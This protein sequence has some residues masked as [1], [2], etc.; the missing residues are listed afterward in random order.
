MAVD[1][2]NAGHSRKVAVERPNF[3]AVVGGNRCNQ[4]VGETKTLACC[5]R[6]VQPVVNACPRLIPWKEDRKC[7]E[8]A[9]EVRIVTIGSSAQ[10]L[11]ANGSR[12][13]NFA[14]V[15][16]SRKM[17]RRG[18]L[19]RA[20]RFDPN[21]R[22]DEDHDDGRRRDLGRSISRLMCPII[23]LSSSMR[24]RRTTSCSES[25]TASVSDSAPSR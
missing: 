5:P 8:D 11:N 22:V 13:D 15:E 4:K 24:F 3:C 21:G 25:T 9:T 18:A 23:A 14:G 20:Q 7:R 12:E 2:T 17:L 10:N 1:E 19:T 6:N 16:E